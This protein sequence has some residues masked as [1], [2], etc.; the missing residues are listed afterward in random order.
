MYSTPLTVSRLRG[1]RG[2]ADEDRGRGG[3]LKQTLSDTLLC[4]G[5]RSVM[6]GIPCWLQLAG[7]LCRVSWEEALGRGGGLLPWQHYAEVGPCSLSICC[8]CS[9]C[10]VAEVGPCSVLLLLPRV[11]L[12]CWALLH[13]PLPPSLLLLKPN[14]ISQVTR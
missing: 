6:V 3:L 4:V 1:G 9:Q 13:V 8:L 2:R 11:L 12:L 10:F 5:L 14:C 7:R